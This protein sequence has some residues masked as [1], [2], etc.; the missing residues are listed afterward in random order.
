MRTPAG[1][2][3]QEVI[4]DKD[5]PNHAAHTALRIGMAYLLTWID[6]HVQWDSGSLKILKPFHGDGDWEIK[7]HPNTK[8][9][10]I[11]Q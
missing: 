10:E 7:M 4:D 2:I 3:H 8:K 11:C 9:C 5:A 6:R 1:E